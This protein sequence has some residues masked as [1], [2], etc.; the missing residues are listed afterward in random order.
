[1]RTVRM[2]VALALLISAGIVHGSWTN[3]WKPS[4]A[5]AE[6]TGR[7]DSVPM[8][9]ETWHGASFE[10]SD[11]E[12]AGAGAVGHL[13]RRYQDSDRGVALTTLL[14]SG[15]PGDIAAHTP[16]VCYPGSGFELSPPTRI[17]VP[18]GSPPQT[19]TFL[20]SV[21][22]RQ[23]PGGLDAL[24]IFW[25]WND[26]TGWKAPEDPRWSYAGAPALSKLYVIRETFGEPFN[27]EADPSLEFMNEFLPTL[28]GILF[29]NAAE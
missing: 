27:P 22:S 15:L 10:I 16:D 18:I 14:V 6:L 19:A 29:A 20:T 17:D 24:R 9:V 4:R 23:G 11:R 28:D 2:V 13:A 7:I 5:L 21:A 8:T 25:A 12:L 3:R 1:M 26:G